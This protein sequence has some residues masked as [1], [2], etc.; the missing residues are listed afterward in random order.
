MLVLFSWLISSIESPVIL[1]MTSAGMPFAFQQFLYRDAFAQQGC[2]QSFQHAKVGLVAKQAFH[3][4][5]KANII[6]HAA[7]LL[8]FLFILDK[9]KLI[10]V[11]LQVNRDYFLKANAVH[12]VALPEISRERA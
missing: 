8:Y 11:G 2:Q 12:T 10:L 3:R 6:A 5:I 1:A 9:S 4:P 7:F